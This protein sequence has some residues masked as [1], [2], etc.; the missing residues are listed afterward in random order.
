MRRGQ[1]EAG[2]RGPVG[3]ELRLNPP[4][5]RSPHCPSPGPPA[6]RRAPPGF[7]RPPGPS[8][9]AAPAIDPGSASTAKGRPPSSPGL[10]RL[11]PA[12]PWAA[13]ASA[14]SFQL[15]ARERTLTLLLS[16]TTRVRDHQQALPGSLQNEF[17]IHSLVSILPPPPG[18]SHHFPKLHQASPLPTSHLASPVTTSPDY[19]PSSPR[20]TSDP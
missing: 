7:G 9:A 15:K 1:K 4:A 14:Q 5:W 10:S 6:A 11:P 16:S 2:S 17:Q 13:P 12:S 20:E 8:A 18:P 19:N 3:L